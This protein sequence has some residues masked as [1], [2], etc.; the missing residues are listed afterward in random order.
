[1]SKLMDRDEVVGRFRRAGVVPII[2]VRNVDASLALIAKLVDAGA[3][4]IEIVFRTPEASKVLS[5]ARKR[6]DG[7]MFAAGTMLDDASVRRAVEAGAHCFVSPGLTAELHEA[8]TAS[9]L[10]LIPGV[11][12]ASEVMNAR[13]WG[14]ALMKYYPA[15]PSNGLVVLAD[16]ANI[17]DNVSFL[18]TGKITRPKLALYGALRNVAAVG[19]SWMLEGAEPERLAVDRESFLGSRPF[20]RSSGGDVGRCAS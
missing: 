13:R 15:E 8:A 3:D 19:G 4:V 7:C 2:T 10:L 18:A 12:T 6:H 16:Y 11:Q 20:A 14:Y 9:G 1:M 17:F 5:E